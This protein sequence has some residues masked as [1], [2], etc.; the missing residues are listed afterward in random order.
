[1]TTTERFSISV[2]KECAARIRTLVEQGTYPSV[3]SAFDAAAD[4]LLDREALK[5]AWW[6]ETLIRCDEAERNPQCLLEP[7]KFFS[8]I[9]AEIARTRKL[10][11]NIK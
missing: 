11:T 7:D 1:M 4:A 8:S 5:N 6:K 3:S 9:R 10:D 2:S